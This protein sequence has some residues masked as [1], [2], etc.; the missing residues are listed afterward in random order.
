MID[1]HCHILPGIDDGAGTLE[2]AVEMCRLAAA[3]GCT[4]MV[5]TPHQ[6]RGVWWNADRAA[7][8]AL[9]RRLQEALDALPAM[10]AGGG[11]GLRVYSGGEIHVDA[12]LL[13][14]VERLGRGGE[15]GGD[16]NNF[17]RGTG[18]LPLAGSRYLLLELDGDDPPDASEDLIHE[19]SVAG[20]RP[21]L[22]HPEFV[23]WM[24]VDPGAVARLVS[25]G[26]L[27]Q[28]TAMSVTG[29]FGR[30]AQADT[31]RLIDAGLVHFVAS[32]SHGPR[33]R[34]PGLS[35]ARQ[36]IAARWGEEE[37]RRLVEDNPRAVIEDRPLPGVAAGRLAR[38]VTP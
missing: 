22:A 31:H 20:W 19:L 21:I 16:G 33:R 3:D 29:D 37:A 9:R 32:D 13:A 28:V 17:E 24:A 38:G 15:R 30:R 27:A 26:A 34:P 11:P 14:E 4:A 6:R 7:L 8:A 25:L 36:V 23:P 2:E 5:A 1:L 35:R 10:E 12:Q 18:V